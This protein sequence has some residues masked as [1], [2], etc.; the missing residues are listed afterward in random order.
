MTIDLLPSK[1]EHKFLLALSFTV[2]LIFLA[3][4]PVRIVERYNQ[5]AA[6]E[7]HLLLASANNAC[8]DCVTFGIA[9]ICGSSSPS[10][11]S[12]FFNLILL[13]L[14][15]EFLRRRKNWKFAVSTLSN[16]LSLAV[17]ALWSYVTFEHHRYG[18]AEYF[19]RL[20][21]PGYLL[22]G[23]NLLDFIVLAV[24]LLIFC[25]QIFCG[26]RFFATAWPGEDKFD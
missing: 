23:A 11:I 22:A 8:A 9:D 17:F 26:A 6:W 24:V 5:A 1:S 12:F 21:F 18:N 2:L 25:F 16:F 4:I 15:H 10:A 13:T 19:R 14:A 7:Q 20:S 3:N